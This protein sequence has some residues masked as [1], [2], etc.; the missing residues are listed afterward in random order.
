MGEVVA[1]ATVTGLTTGIGA[2]A[3]YGGKQLDQRVEHIGIV[4]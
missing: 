1:V 3:Y 2:A 4:P